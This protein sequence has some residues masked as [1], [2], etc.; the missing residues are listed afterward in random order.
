MTPRPR[1]PNRGFFH[2]RATMRRRIAILRQRKIWGCYPQTPEVFLNQRR[3]D[4]LKIAVG[5]HQCDAMQ[6][7]CNLEPIKGRAIH[8]DRRR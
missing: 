7:R 3:S 1:F 5:I 2:A 4:G 6:A 8:E